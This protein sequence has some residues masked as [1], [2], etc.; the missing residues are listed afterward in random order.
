MKK[1]ILTT[2]A[3]A[4]SAG[5]AMAETI[6][7]GT[8]GA[9]APWNFVNDAGEIDGF[10]RE[11][12]DEL[13]KRANLE[14]EWVKNDWDSIIP[15]LVSGNYDAIIAGMSITDERD[16]VIDFT[17][18]YTPPDPSAYV[19]MSDGVDLSGGVIAAQTGTIQAGYVAESGA[20]LVEFAS[21]EETIAAVRNG[22]ADAV[23]ADKSFLV[24]FTEDGSGLLF[25]GDEVPL[26]GGV[27]MGI[28]ESDGEL[29]E[30]FNAAIQS[31]KDDGTLNELITKWEVSSTF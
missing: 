4:L 22:E 24:P 13:C 10:E 15:N 11:L 1:L 30:K 7:L 3:L 21:P 26:G 28:R 5:M 6:R 27:G 25:V 29:K 14:C 19:A 8:E 31:M 20:T 9:Y 16:E 12:G 23:L 17:Q 2:A 18:N